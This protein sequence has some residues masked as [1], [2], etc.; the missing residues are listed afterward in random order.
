MASKY[1]E[2]QIITDGLKSI[3]GH[4]DWIGSVGIVMPYKL[5]GEL[6]GNIKIVSIRQPN[7][8]IVS[9]D[10]GEPHP[11]IK[12]CSLKN[13]MYNL[14][15]FKS[16]KF[17]YN[18]G[19]VIKNVK[20]I[21]QK[22]NS[23]NIMTYK[24]KCLID[25]YEYD[26]TQS[27]LLV[28]LKQGNT[29]CPVCCNHVVIDGVNSFA[30]ISPE[31][32]EWFVD[33]DLSHKIPRFLNKEIEFE[34]P[35]C[36]RRFYMKPQ[37]IKKTPSCI[38]RDGFSYPE[39][40]FSNI[41]NQLNVDYIYQLCSK[42]F[43][44]CSCY[45]YDFYFVHNNTP[46]IFEL[47]GGLGHG[48][49]DIKERDSLSVDMIKDR[50]A[51]NNN[52]LLYRIDV[53]Y[54][55]IGKRFEY[56]KDNICK[57]HLSDIFDLTTIN[58]NDVRF[59]SDKSLMADVCNDFNN[60]Q[61]YIKSL[62]DK[63]NISADTARRYLKTGTKIGLCYYDPKNGFKHYMDNYYDYE[64]NKYKKIIKVIYKDKTIYINGVNSVSSKI[65]SVFDINITNRT[66]SRHLAN[67]SIKSRKGLKFSYAT[68]EEIENLKEV[69]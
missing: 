7:K 59:K 27:N 13:K 31:I 5:D 26:I 15:G 30:D 65:K 48:H 35:Y 58:W 16:L 29:R 45:K 36:Y 51:R 2:L 50:I 53:N 8:V 22:L 34:C 17:K 12:E 60:G 43:K 19:D 46:Y 54:P 40:M 21:E 55:N 42:D 11:V 9:I 23:D 38:C 37:N 49:K 33:K 4:I 24:V 18:I 57:S 32:V 20:I 3:N 14:L 61:T 67:P 25:G 68:E 1:K 28:A 69:I 44:W 10:G 52:V 47:D 39:K 41:L 63:Y 62:S 6:C 56:I 64:N 66:I